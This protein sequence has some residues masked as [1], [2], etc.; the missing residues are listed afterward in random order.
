APAPTAPAP[1]APAPTA[2]APPAPEPAEPAPTLEALEARLRQANEWLLAEC[3]AR[4]V[5][6]V[7]L[8]PG[9]LEVALGP[10]APKDLPDDLG[11]ALSAI[12]GTRWSVVVSGREGGA[13]LAE[14]RRETARAIE[15]RAEAHPLVAAALEAFPGARVS[16]VR[17]L[18][19]PSAARA[20]RADAGPGIDPVAHDAEEADPGPLLDTDDLDPFEED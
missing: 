16:A 19:A 18:S 17:P 1:T 9:V 7:R 14:T 4:D 2:P 10:S 8:R 13:T 15:A 20:A 11:R 6:P 12:E 3:L 5:R